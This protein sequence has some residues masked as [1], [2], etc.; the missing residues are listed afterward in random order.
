[1]KRLHVLLIAGAVLVMSPQ[2]VLAQ[3]QHGGGA[4]GGGAIP[5]SNPTFSDFQ[6]AIALQ[7]TEA[8]SAQV[9]SWMQSTAGL[10][11]RLDHFSHTSESGESSVFSNELEALKE[12]F[13]VNNMARSEFLAGLSGTQRSALKKHLKK[14]E[15]SSRALAG[16]FADAT[17]ASGESPNGKPFSKGLQRAIKA[18][19]IE[20]HEQQKLVDEMG[21]KV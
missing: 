2:W 10:S 13:E 9:R 11:T 19:A 3:H 21:V 7:A 15:E 8:Q 17:R 12:A 1:M 6:K 5:S 18:I 20:Q 16:A 4:A 14:L